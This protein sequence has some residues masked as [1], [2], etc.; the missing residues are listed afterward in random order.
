[1][2]DTLGSSA[3][4]A[5]TR[6]ALELVADPAVDLF[7]RACLDA[8]GPQATSELRRRSLAMLRHCWGL[9]QRAY[10]IRHGHEFYSV[11]RCGDRLNC[12]DLTCDEERARGVAQWWAGPPVDVT[13]VS[14]VD[15]FPESW[16]SMGV[17]LHWTRPDWLK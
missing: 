9:V 3:L 11:H 1:M 4:Q 12:L 16:I 6:L 17:A 7:K 14:G 5:R 8:L 10:G 15:L 2:D 13:W